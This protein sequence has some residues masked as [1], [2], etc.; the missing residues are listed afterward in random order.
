MPQKKK[1]LLDV[2]LI[3]LIFLVILLLGNYGVFI[4][5]NFFFGEGAYQLYLYHAEN[6]NSAGWRPDLGLGLS[7]LFGDPGAFHVWALF[8]WWNYLFPNPLIGY[9]SAVIALLLTRPRYIYQI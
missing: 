7:F 5:H 4:G 8:R 1:F 3:P 6:M 9:S 2:V